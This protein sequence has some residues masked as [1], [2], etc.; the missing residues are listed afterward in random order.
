MII[1]LITFPLATFY[2]LFVALKGCG[3]LMLT[4]QSLA[5]LFSSVFPGTFLD[6]PA[7][8]SPET[9]GGVP[10]RSVPTALSHP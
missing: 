2:F 8:P 9:W 10:N 3:S 4:P 7:V 1:V 6:V 5:C